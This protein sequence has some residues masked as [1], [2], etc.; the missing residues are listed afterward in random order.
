MLVSPSLIPRGSPLRSFS[1]REE[2]NSWYILYRDAVTPN[3]DWIITPHPHSANLFIAAGGS[4]HAWKFLPNLG[5][6]ITQMLD[7]TLS[8]EMSNKWAWDRADEGAAC[9]MYIPTRDLKDAVGE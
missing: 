1:I 2:R 8:E 5:K 7:G 9:E 4:F 3:Q 6:Y